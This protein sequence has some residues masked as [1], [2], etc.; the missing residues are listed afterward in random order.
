MEALWTERIAVS[1]EIFLD[2]VEILVFYVSNGLHI[3]NFTGVAEELHCA[4]VEH[5]NEA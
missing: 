5:I 4:F 1:R 3:S 2:S